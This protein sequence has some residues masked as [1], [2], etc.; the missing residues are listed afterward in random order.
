MAEK[1]TSI[2]KNLDKCEKIIF[3]VTEVRTFN[4]NVG[5][6]QEQITINA[7]VLVKDVPENIW[8][9][10]N[11]RKQNFKTN[12][13]KKIENNLLCS[14]TD[15]FH[16]LN[17]GILISAYHA[18]VITRDEK[19]YVEIYLKDKAVHGNI[20]GG[21]TYT[22]ICTNKNLITFTK[23]VN[24]EIMTG[25]EEFYE[26]LAAARNTSVQ[27]QDKSIAELQNKFDIIKDALMD[28][29]YFENI[30]YKENSEGEID[31]SDLISILTMFNIERFGD[32]KHPIIA[33]NSKKRC[34]D[35]YLEDYEKG[36]ENPYVKMQSIMV[37]IFALVDYI[38]NN[39]A[40]AYN[41]TGG[42]YGAIKGVVCST[43]DK[44]FDRVFG[45]PGQKSDYSSPKGFLYPIIGAFRSLLEEDDGVMIWKEDPIK[46]F[47]A[48]GSQL[49]S[50]VVDTNKT[51]GN[52]PNATGKFSGL[53]ENLYTAVE[54][55]YLKNK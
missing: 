8:M 50:S 46:V 42:K 1:V 26:D 45:Q 36:E 49:I 17:R 53:W 34:V 31:I 25:I 43:K 14:P 37:D 51:L 10:T 44:K 19:K 39:I 40:K 38:E 52:N 47:E 3:P 55:Y 12:V 16:L 11:P 5:T 4:E 54:I 30:A 29:P 2:K 22:I 32:K 27:V 33:Y 15:N 13:A 41:Q 9:D 7:R 20:D 18:R 35:L 23:R 28:E 21:H 48:I 6:E 24:I